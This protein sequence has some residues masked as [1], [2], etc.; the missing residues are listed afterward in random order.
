MPRGLYGRAALIVA[1]PF[2]ALQVIVSVAFIQRYFEDV[3]R[4]M[5]D[6]QSLP[7]SY[8][9]EVVAQD[10][11]D[12]ARQSLSAPLE[13][14]I[15]ESAAPDT[16]LSRVWY[17]F[18]GFT[19][20]EKLAELYDLRALDLR[21]AGRVRAWI[22]LGDATYEIAFDRRRVSARNPHQLLVLLLGGGLIMI[23]ISF[24]FMRNQLR[25]IRRL[26][27]AAEAFGKGRSADYAPRGASE[28]RAAGAAFLDMRAR[29]ERQIEQRTL[30]LSGVS[31]DLRTPLTRMHLALSLMDDS[32]EIT[33]LRGDVN[34]MGKMID[35]FLDFA[36]MGAG[37]EPAQTDVKALLEEAATG[38][39][40]AGIVL[41]LATPLPEIIAMVRPVALRRAVDNLISNAGRYGTRVALSC[42]VLDK[43]IRIR[44]EDDGPGIPPQDRE[45]AQRPFTRLD[46]ARGQNQGGSVGLGL[47][48][49]AD[50][51]RRHGGTLRLGESQALG[52]L[53]ADL[54]LAR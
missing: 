29:I 34:D 37:E 47:A 11:I 4:Q 53:L 18:S 3:T 40:R 16:A 28:V 7:L 51:A 49:A 5:V 48:M 23:V 6:T 17:D 27:R 43:S 30:L 36:R 9:L 39:R 12:A 26:A 22:A 35:A 10:G 14:S 38:A 45:A 21:D 44:I 52:G 33:T 54:V 32:E 13:I 46:E 8:F 50:T 41:D 1:L 25:P 31:H 19:I 42:N 20:Q 15:K 2:L 24:F